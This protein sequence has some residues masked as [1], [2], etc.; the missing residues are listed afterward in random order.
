[1]SRLCIETRGAANWRERLASPDTQWRRR[2]SALETAA[3]WELASSSSTGLPEPIAELFRGSDYGDPELMFALAEHKVPLP[4][5]R[6]ESQC[7]VWALLHTGAGL[8]SLSAEAKANEP[9]GQNNES[10]A[11]WLVAEESDKSHRNRETRWEH[12]R[13]HL[14]TIGADGYS[15]VAYQLLHRCA[16]AVI[17][18]GRL[19]LTN[20]AFV[21]QAFD[22]PKES[23][24]A[25]SRFC[26]AMGLRAERGRMRMTVVGNVHLGVGWADC[27]FATDEQLASLF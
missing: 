4:G 22:S 25:F 5:G 8:V 10:L 19:R 18:A 15:Q 26:Q 17:E 24:E 3:S 9:F 27:P 2:Y 13:K 6:T 1:M 14:P 23:F 16:T 21:V 20:A 12:I 7:D 11:E